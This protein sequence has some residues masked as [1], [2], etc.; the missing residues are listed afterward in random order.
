MKKTESVKENST[1]PI[2]NNIVTDPIKSINTS[3]NSASN[4]IKIH[5]I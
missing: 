5:N 1:T 3:I 2:N 4:Q